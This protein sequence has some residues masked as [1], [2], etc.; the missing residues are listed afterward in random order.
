[1][2]DI[3]E[4]S[5]QVVLEVAIIF[6]VIGII[7]FAF[8]GVWPP[9]VS[10][11]S[12]SMEP[13]MNVGDMVYVVET[14]NG[15]NVVTMKESNSSN[16]FGKKGE[17]II[18]QPNGNES[19]TPVIHRAI[20]EVDKGDKWVEDVNSSHLPNRTKTCE[21]V[22]NCPAPNSGYI[23]KGDANLYYDQAG[24]ISKP[25]QKDWVIS[26]AELRIPYVG[27]VRIIIDPI[28]S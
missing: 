4:E 19:K 8:G 28:I 23:T 5:L 7:P 14:D 15:N 18:Y 3:V 26:K 13:N 9:Y 17:V 22:M 24:G 12:D 16:E 10:I 2:K 6:T 1:M 27:Y 11:I 21:K 20:I 25:V